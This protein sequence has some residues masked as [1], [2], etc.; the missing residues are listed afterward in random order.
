MEPDDE[1]KK[2]KLDQDFDTPFSLPYDAKGKLP[3]DHPATDD[4]MDSDELYDQGLSATA[5]ADQS[6]PANSAVVSY[7]PRPNS[8]T[9]NKRPKKS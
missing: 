5:G 8:K 7:N 2:E 9:K 6:E 1:E 3:I 4:Q